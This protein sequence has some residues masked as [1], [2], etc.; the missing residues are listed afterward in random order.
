MTDHSANF[1]DIAG[2][3]FGN[4]T[5]LDFVGSTRGHALWSCRCTC[6]VEFEEQSGNLRSGKVK[7]C[8]AC[9]LKLQPLRMRLVTGARLIA[10]RRAHV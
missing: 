4:V 6:G 8:N 1:V 10:R 3:Q 5:V 9:R 2:E 7:R